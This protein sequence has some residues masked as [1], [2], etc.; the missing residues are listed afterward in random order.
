MVSTDRA[1]GVL[2][3][4]LQAAAG[5]VQLG[6]QHHCM[7]V[8]LGVQLSMLGCCREWS[9]CRRPGA[10]SK[11]RHSTEACHDRDQ[12]RLLPLRRV[13]AREAYMRRSHE[14]AVGLLAHEGGRQLT[15]RTPDDALR[16]QSVMFALAKALDKVRPGLLGGREV[17]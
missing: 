1:V 9:A 6:Q 12:W 4:Q 7:V 3:E 13:E 15:E 2:C 8:P 10:S 5:L 16:Y 17:C 11:R 14:F